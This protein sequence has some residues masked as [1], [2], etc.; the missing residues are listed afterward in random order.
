M[1]RN[2]TRATQRPDRPAIA[3]RRVPGYAFRGTQSRSAAS[4]Q[5]TAG[6]RIRLAVEYPREG[7]IVVAP[8]YT[9]RIDA[10]APRVEIAIDGGGWCSCRRSD[11]YWWF[12]WSDYDS[13]PHQAIVRAA[14]GSG[15]ETVARV[16]RFVVELPGT[17][18]P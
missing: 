10:S 11:D 18:A 15:P 17:G 9:F 14:A 5:E 3:R 8:A 7:E 1:I 4:G 16:C 2:V 13:G 12:D 6:G